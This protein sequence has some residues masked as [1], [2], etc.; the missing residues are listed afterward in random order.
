[1]EFEPPGP[2]ERRRATGPIAGL[3]HSLRR[4]LD[5]GSDFQPV[6]VPGPHDWLAIHSE[7]GQSFEQFKKSWVNQPAKH[8]SKIHL[9]SLGDS[10]AHLEDLRRYAAMYFQMEVRVL[11]PIPLHA[12]N[13]TT[14]VNPVTG[15]QQLLTT[16][17]LRVLG[18]GLEPDTF[19]LLAIT[20]EDLYPDPSWNFVFGQASPAQSVGVYSFARY[21]PAFD[22]QEG[23]EDDQAV[24]L[25]RS[26]K[27]LVHETAHMF[28]LA[29]CIFFHC[30]MNGSNHLEESDQRPMHLC[31]V[32]LRKLQFCIGFDVI[33]RYSGL[34]EFYKTVGFRPEAEWIE[35]RLR[36]I[37]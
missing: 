30:V 9:Q 17:I 19:C 35:R 26:C 32:C 11:Q 15:H 27:V 25:R 29:H 37:E 20:M 8:Q 1:M 28:G 24:L 33:N 10:P 18:K 22:G 7:A 13:F 21:D 2:E 4:A 5:P 36:K 31:P 14:R 16:D 23:S 6:P 34:L 12:Q 3:P